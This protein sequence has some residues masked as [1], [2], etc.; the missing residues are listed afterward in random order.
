MSQVR[1]VADY[2]KTMELVMARARE[3]FGKGWISMQKKTF[4]L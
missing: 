4:K 1:L 2:I 3:K